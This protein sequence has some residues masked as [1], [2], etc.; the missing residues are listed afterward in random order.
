MV[1]FAKFELP[2]YLHG[3]EDRATY[4]LAGSAAPSISLDELISLSSDRATTENALKFHSLKLPLGPVQGSLGLRRA[5]AALYQGQGQGHDQGEPGVPG[6]GPV[7]APISADHVITTPGTTGANFL[8]LQ[9]LLGAAD[10]AICLYPTYPQL[11]GLVEAVAGQ[12][13]YWAPKPEDG[14]RPDLSELR[15]LIKPDGSTKV[16]VLNNPNNPTGWHFD[17]EL[18]RQILDLAREKGLIVLA[19]EIFRP[20][21]ATD[22]TPPPSFIEHDDYTKVIVTGS[23]SKV[24]GMSGVRIGWVVCRDPAIIDLLVNARQ[25]TVQSTG[26]ID[27]A[28]ATEVLSDRCRPALLRRHLAYQHQDLALLDAF[29]ETNKDLV[30]WTRPTAGATAFVKFSAPTREPLDDVAFC[31]ALLDKKGV[32]L[33]P[34][35]LCFGGNSPTDFRGYVRV[36]IT[37]EPGVLQKALD[38]TSEFLEEYRSGQD[39]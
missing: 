12:V 20:L 29:V 32:L 13:S 35:S 25:Y 33:G 7:S 19:D 15:G 18:Q 31:Q 16:L 1:K 22:I 17:R 4:V 34:G 2:Q 38:L 28:I 8:V 11:T 9:G 6:S 10:H 21:F 5:I 37:K 24:W 26:V 30:S 3:N 14:W 27:E 36:H 39:K 23:L